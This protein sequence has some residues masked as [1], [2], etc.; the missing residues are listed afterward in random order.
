MK[1]LALIVEDNKNMADA[2]L[3]A[4]A[5]AGYTAEIA[6]DGAVAVSKL[7]YGPIP[8]LVLLDL[9]LPNVKGGAILD[10]I[11]ENKRLSE[12]RVIVVTANDR[13][14]EVYRDTADLVLLKPVGFNQVRDIA[15][16]ML[17]QDKGRGVIF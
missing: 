17:P 3:E 6:L 7:T 4:V 15:S 1:P 8:H 5:L 11:R 2:F 9:N 12:T 16:R 13:E 10:L 14:A